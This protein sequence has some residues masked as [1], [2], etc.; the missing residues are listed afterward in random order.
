MGKLIIMR[1]LIDI[2]HPAHVHFFKNTIRELEEQGA[3]I[4]VTARRKDVSLELLDNYKIPYIERG[5][6][7]RRVPGKILDMVRIDY[8]LLKLARSFRPDILMGIHNPYIAQVGWLLRRPAFI[9]TDTEH[10]KVGNLITFPFATRI[11]TPNCFL[12]ELGEKQVRYQ[13]YHEL[14]Y[15][16]PSWFTPN[17]G[18]L[19]LLNIKEGESYVI[20]RF[21]SGKALHDRGHYGLT[22]EMKQKAIRELQKHARVFISSES[23]LPQELEKYRVRI[24]PERIHDVLSYASLYLGDGATMASECAVLGTPAVYVSDLQMGYLKDEEDVYG[25]L[26]QFSSTPQ[27]ARQAIQRGVDILKNECE[28]E[29]WQ[30]R[31]KVL[32][33]DKIDVTDFMVDYLRNWCAK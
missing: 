16:H 32:L 23:P 9:F 12:L 18:V 27:G 25:L 22:L 33:A 3:C 2:G 4:Q 19:S 26:F 17:P 6:I 30:E 13:G 29:R 8:K 28:R 31:Q 21:V 5:R 7:H 11:F 14:A 15:L 10:S 1:I 20:L 24:P